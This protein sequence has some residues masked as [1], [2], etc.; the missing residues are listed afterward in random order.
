MNPTYALANRP[1]LF[2]SYAVFLVRDDPADSY[3]EVMYLRALASD[4]VGHPNIIKLHDVI[5]ADNDR[6]LYMTFDY[7]ETDLSRVIKARIL[8]PVVSGAT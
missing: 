8:E 1:M 5:R 4:G 7:S 2:N 3:R 6:D